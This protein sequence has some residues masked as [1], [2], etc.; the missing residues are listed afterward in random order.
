MKKILFSAA[1]FFLA[2][3]EGKACA[4]SYSE[5]YYFSLFSQSIIRDKAYIP[6]LHTY[7][8]R[9]FEGPKVKVIDDNI[10][11]W[12]KYFGNRFNYDETE[13]LVNHMNI[14]DLNQYKNGGTGNALLNRLGAYGNYREGIDYLIEAK[15]L[16]P[17]MRIN[18]VEGSDSFYYREN[19]NPQNATLLNY[20]RTVAALTSLYNETK[21]PEIKARY[22]YQL[23]RFNH[24]TR[25]YQQAIDAFNQY[26]KP[27]NVKSSPYWLALDQLAGAQRGLNQGQEANWNFFQVFMHSN[28]R[29]E[30]AFVSM[31]LSDSASFN[32]IL[33]RAQAPEEKNMAYFL[34]GFDDFT[35]PIPMMEKMYEENPDSEILKVMA[36]RSINELERNYLPVYYPTD[37]EQKENAKYSSSFKATEDKKSAESDKNSD[38]SEKKEDKSESFWSKIVNFFKNLFGSSNASSKKATE[39]ERHEEQSDSD[40]LNNPN[41][42]PVYVKNTNWYGPETQHDFSDDLAGF[43]EKAKGKSTDEF[44]Q[45]AD[46]YMKFL[47]KD[48]EASNKILADIKTG[49]P[50]YIEQINRLKMLNEITAQPRIDADF[51]NK[52]MQKYPNLFAEK[53]KSDS[54]DY[55]NETPN[56]A[57]F[58]RDILANRYYL[59]GED[60]KSYLMNNRLSDLQYNPNSTLVKKVQEYYQK[61]NKTKF[62]QE[63]VN[64]NIDDVGDVNSFFNI[65]YGDDQMRQANFEKA[66]EYYAQ[67]KDFKGIPRYDYVWDDATNTTKPKVY[68]AGEYNGFS[69]I[70]DLIFGHNVW[71]SF[72]SPDE[73]SMVADGAMSFDFIKN[74][75]N[76][77]ELADALVKLNKI[78]AGKDASAAANANQLIGNLLYNTSSLGYYRHVFVMDIDNSNGGK[79]DFWTTDREPPYQFYYKD[80]T[81]QTFIKPDIFDRS[82]GYYQKALNLTNDREQKARIL[83]Q[84]ASAEQGKYYQ[85]EAKQHNDT[86][87]DDPNWE[88]K[89]NEFQAMLDK[90]RNEKYRTYFAQLK[91]RFADT[92]TA[93]QLQGSCSYFGYFMKRK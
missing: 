59:Q 77:L 35:N 72:S 86:N 33:K 93:Q 74:N 79:Y 78:A 61:P 71:E 80:F 81:N 89:N 1:V 66:K 31:K 18:F 44:W 4:D 55:Y 8:T 34:L 84:M 28:T 85:W 82:I 10:E 42:L 15:Y 58:I 20:D 83:F 49:N 75:M 88:Q 25:N 45:I 70:P 52:I 22:G 43:I 41:R 69:G 57:D 17:F 26:V 3:N 46:A 65:I 90:E 39:S 68:A 37:S 40:L 50:E 24:Y 21:S 47:K 36:A 5:G 51:E 38:D 13:Y 19:E 9:F 67:V 12:R 23:V 53:P 60:G 11:L 30:S 87:Y 92:Q 73:Q 2:V 54:T 16:E 62:E 63:V 27:L 32:N 91:A 6:F 29:K 64:K 76:K 14:N 56:T 7:D 48:Y